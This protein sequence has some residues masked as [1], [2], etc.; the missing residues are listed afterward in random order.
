MAVMKFVMW[1]IQ[2]NYENSKEW[3][4]FQRIIYYQMIINWIYSSLVVTI[5][6]IVS[7]SITFT[8]AD[9]WDSTKN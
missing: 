7:V 9:M 6:I 8:D 5:A 1:E 3:L 4:Q 2:K